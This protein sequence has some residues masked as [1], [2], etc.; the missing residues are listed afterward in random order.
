[1]AVLPDWRG[2]GVGSALLRA[3]LDIAREDGRPPPFLHAQT[4]A[5][6]FYLRSGFK[7]VGEVHLEAGLPHQTMIQIPDLS[8]CVL[9]ETAGG[10]ALSGQ[11]AIRAAGIHMAAQAR[12]ELLLFSH[13]LDPALYDDRAFLD[14]MHRVALRGHAVPVR[15]LVLHA[16]PAIRKGHRLIDM[17]RHLSSKIQ[18]R[19]I[20]AEFNRH[21]ESYL[22]ADGHGYVLRPLADVFEGSA[23]FNA[24][25][26]VRRLHE[27]FEH[28]WALGEIHQ[29]LR[30]LYL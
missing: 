13:D 11:A 15:I 9:G 27:Q 1:M 4:T 18:I 24:P 14:E 2:R 7:P 28:I 17:A 16:E 10:F 12:R 8:Q 5:V 20:P 26:E 21:T 29:E 19:R 25:L 30:R 3:L 23:D 6:P 22:L